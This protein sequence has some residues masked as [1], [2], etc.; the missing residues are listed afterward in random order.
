ME[1]AV[2]KVGDGAV[3]T[4]L[5]GFGDGGTWLG[6]AVSQQEMHTTQGQ[7]GEG[8]SALCSATFRLH[9]RGAS[10]GLGTCRRG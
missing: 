9:M 3:A 1:D 7:G 6:T 5:T 4:N 10:F 2:A 8:V